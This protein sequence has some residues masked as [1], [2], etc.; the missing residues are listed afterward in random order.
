MI[1]HV[2][3]EQVSN[4]YVQVTADDGILQEM[5]DFFT[6]SS[7]GHQFSPSFRNKYWDGKIRL[8]NLKTRQIY[9][10]LV[11]YIKKFCK[12][13]NRTFEYLDE[14]KEL[15]PIDT[16]NLASAL[17]LPL[18]P[19]DY[20]YLASS[21]GLTKKRS[22]LISPTASGKSLIIYLMIRYLLNSGKKRGLLIV[23]T[24]NL[25]SQMHSDFKEYS[26]NN[27]WDVDK[28]C[29]QIYGGQSKIA[30]S[31]LVI[32]T[33]QSIFE[34]PQKYFKQFDFIIGDEAH[35]FKAKSLTT[36]MNNLINCDVR[37]GTTGT[38][39]DSKI[40][41]LVLEGLFGPTFKVI[42]TKE[43][44]DRKQLADFKIKCVVLKY[45]ETTCKAVKGFTYQEEMDFLVQHEARNNFIRDLAVSLKGNSL[46]LFTYVEKHGRILK[47]LVDNKVLGRK[48][49]RKVFFIHGGV[50]ADDREAV[51]RITEKEN[52]AIIIA[53]YGTFST[54]VNI[55]NL[56]N[57]VF[58]S[59]TKSKIRA[60]QS[61]GR[62][63]RLGDNKD[64]A[65]LYDIADDLRYGPYTNFT[66]KHYEERIKI[67]SEEKF[68]FTS[69]N[70]R[71]N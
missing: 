68:I 59:P 56:H 7:P 27:G 15:Y 58:S 42:S 17:S 23:P 3:I 33:W 25:V 30:D 29:Q 44:I 21:V 51:R 16:K 40:N 12:D 1:D 57:I 63:L 65:T 70:V 6:F 46:I 49:E 48:D 45:P 36:I 26:V 69:S 39:D 67:Y 9:V 71:I 5:S 43:L 11:P 52:D 37:I 13:T 2:V 38:L 41:K 14:Q 62:V 4:I 24:I 32:S 10:G 61:I 22:V 34:M 47:T 28:H 60:L 54:G 18:E 20:Q 8:F 35:T 66:L 64:A 55:R 50:E 31:D 19:R 53:S